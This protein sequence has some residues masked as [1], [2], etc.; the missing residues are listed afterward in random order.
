MA[1]ATLSDTLIKVGIAD[2][3][4]GNAPCE[5]E[6]LLGSCVGVA[7]WDGISRIGGLAHV[8]LPVSDT[9]TNQPGKY[10]NSAVPALRQ[11]LIA[12]GA[13]PSNLV[14]RIAGGAAMF[15]LTT[16]DDIGSRNVQAVKEHLRGH[17][18]PLAGSHVG[19]RQGRVIR[20]SLS[21]GLVRVFVARDQ[22]AVV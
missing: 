21:T 12:R 19:G 4:Y 9:R 20:F 18:I 3:G 6:T 11:E 22:V 8:M 5:L 10:A 7:V 1:I 15:G 16:G 17:G 14:A 2:I 13:I